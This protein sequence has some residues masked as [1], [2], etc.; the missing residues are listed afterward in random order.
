[1]EVYV[2]S[3]G[4]IHNKM[5]FFAIRFQKPIVKVQITEDPEKID[6]TN[7]LVVYSSNNAV[8]TN[9]LTFFVGDQVRAAGIAVKSGLEHEL[10]LAVLNK[11]DIYYHSY[12]NSVLYVCGKPNCIPFRYKNIPKTISF[13]ALYK[14]TKAHQ[15]GK[16]AIDH[17]VL[18]N[19]FR[20]NNL[21]WG[22]WN[23]WWYFIRD[24]INTTFKPKIS[25]NITLEIV[26]LFKKVWKNSLTE[27]GYSIHPELC[28]CEIA[29]EN[30]EHPGILCLSS[31]SKITYV[32]PMIVSKE[33]FHFLPVVDKT[34][35]KCDLWF[36]LYTNKY[37][38]FNNLIYFYVKQIKVNTEHIK[39]ML[40]FLKNTAIVKYKL[41]QENLFFIY[42]LLTCNQTS[43]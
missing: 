15:K 19:Y 7:I 22:K 12:H 37:N 1:M 14:I 8:Q 23:S 5:V 18:C 3:Y 29:L 21:K 35:I 11:S 33:W 9:T 4:V 25:K 32:S 30:T 39:N 38:W 27:N 28:F 17:I 31:H 42:Q 20:R 10:L 26:A 16:L 2:E 41:I 24:I 34:N 36:P 40:L 43:L 6:T 13:K